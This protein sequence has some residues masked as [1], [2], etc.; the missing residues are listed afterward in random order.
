MYLCLILEKSLLS[1]HKDKKY[2]LSLS[3]SHSYKQ[4]FSLFPRQA[5]CLPVEPHS[6][7]ILCWESPS[8]SFLVLFGFI[9]GDGSNTGL[10]FHN[11]LT[12]HAPEMPSESSGEIS[13]CL[14]GTP[15]ALCKCDHFGTGEIISVQF[16]ACPSVCL[17][18]HSMRLWG[19]VQI[20]SVT[21]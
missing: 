16:I 9:L 19:H 2:S 18:L 20:M 11:Y 5:I 10:S 15:I 14:L 7:S 1:M 13:G 6:C 17:S 3:T 12:T 21:S 8:F 4:H